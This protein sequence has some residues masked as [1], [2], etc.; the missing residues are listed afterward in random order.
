MIESY[1][2]QGSKYVEVPRLKYLVVQKYGTKYQKEWTWI[3][4]M[5]LIGFLKIP[6]ID[7]QPPKIQG[8]STWKY[9][10]VLYNYCNRAQQ[11]ILFCKTPC[12]ILIFNKR[13]WEGIISFLIYIYIY[14]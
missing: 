11:L 6:S 2:G 13:K 12:G 7:Q 4:L 10:L 8:K 3:P 9:P 14:I 5:L 1:G